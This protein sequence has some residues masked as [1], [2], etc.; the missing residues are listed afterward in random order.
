M[1]EDC[2]DKCIA[3]EFLV[4]G[5]QKSGTSSLTYYLDEHP[6]IRILEKEAHF[7][8]QLEEPTKDSV[9]EYCSRFYPASD[10][11]LRGETTPCYLY[12][13]Y[14]A[15]R[16]KTFAPNAKLVVIL[17]D[18]YQRAYSHYWKN[19]KNGREK[20]GFLE[21]LQSEK[22]RMNVD[23]WHSMQF[24][25]VARSRYAEQLDRYYELF[26]QD[27]IFLMTLDQLISDP[28]KSLSSLLQFLEIDYQFLSSRLGEK[29]NVAAKSHSKLLFKIE[30]WIKRVINNP[31]IWAQVIKKV[32][33]MKYIARLLRKIVGYLNNNFNI[34][35]NYEYPE[36][37]KDARDYIYNEIRLDVKRLKTVYNI[38][39]KWAK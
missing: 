14:A 18:P 13:P 11:Y 39:E 33:L 5:A 3:P 10:K 29:R 19:I 1:I 37:G 9:C 21:A 30:G 28:E 26:D 35:S 25:Y 36:M 38:H 2:D 15:N 6:Q 31:P 24:S 22:D 16:I 23:H 34:K 12:M 8:D 17:R 20:L 4:I 27:K 32:R 7:F